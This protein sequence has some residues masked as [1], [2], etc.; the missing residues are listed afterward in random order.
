MKNK[1]TLT[2]ESELEDKIAREQISKL[3]TKIETIN[4]RTKAHTLEIR[5]LKKEKPKKLNHIQ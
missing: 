2:A 3:W 5:K 4:E 1:I